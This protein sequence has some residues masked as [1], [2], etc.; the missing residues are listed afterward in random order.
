VLEHTATKKLNEMFYFGYACDL[1][2]HDA[3]G[4]RRM[5]FAR[6]RIEESDEG[7]DSIDVS[8]VKDRV[9][10]QTWDLSL[11]EPVDSTLLSPFVR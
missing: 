9:M 7:F 2:R 1:D 5:L 10:F 4:R 3:P 8:Q 6:S 11:V